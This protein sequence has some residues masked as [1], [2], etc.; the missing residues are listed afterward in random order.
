[1][2]WTATVVAQAWVDHGLVLLGRISMVHRW[3]LRSQP[4]KFGLCRVIVAHF[5]CELGDRCASCH[6]RHATDVL[7]SSSAAS[8]PFVLCDVCPFL[9]F[10]IILEFYNF[11]PNTIFHCRR[12]SSQIFV[13]SLFS[14]FFAQFSVPLGGTQLFMF[15]F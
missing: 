10:F 12:D 1:M 9:V 5:D 15:Q 3:T 8:S 14:Q 11:I 7:F 2:T 6:S 13:I 4:R